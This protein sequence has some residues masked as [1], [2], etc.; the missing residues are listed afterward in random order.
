MTEWADDWWRGGVLY[1]IYVR[2]FADSNGDGV[3]DLDGVIDKL[4]YLQWLGISGVWLSPV[5]PSPNRDWGYDITDYRSVHPE[6]GD[7][8]TFDRLVR[9]AD[10]RGIKVL[11]D[12]VPN[13]TS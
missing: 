11:V 13:H 3:G 6:L 5:M 4:D 7:F 9:E 12:L 8:E 1:Q 2:S 10:A